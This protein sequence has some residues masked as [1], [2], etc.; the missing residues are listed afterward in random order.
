MNNQLDEMSV[1]LKHLSIAD[2]LSLQEQIV[3]ELKVKTNGNGHSS[4]PASSKSGLGFYQPSV[5]EVEAEL[6]AIFTPEELAEISSMRAEDLNLPPLPKS[7][8]G[9][10][11]EDREDRF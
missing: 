7:L 4:K 5:E 3:Q 11:S 6:A 10:I 9:M 1:K 2:L 8:A